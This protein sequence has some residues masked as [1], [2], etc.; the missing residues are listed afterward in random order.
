MR[1][2]LILAGLA[3]FAL[4]SAASAQSDVAACREI[5]DSLV[6]LRCYDDVTK[7]SAAKPAV[8]A[9]IGTTDP[10]PNFGRYPTEVYRGRI[11]TPDFRG[12]DRAYAMLRTRIRDGAKA[13]PNF[14][15]YL[16][17][18]EIGCGAGC[19]VVPVVD[20]RTG[21]VLDFPLGGEDNLSL[22]LKYRRDSRLIV[23]YWVNEGVCRRED[24]VWTGSGFER[25][26]TRELGD[27]EVCYRH[28]PQ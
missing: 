16:T 15:G 6:R 13:G 25:G 14:A 11:M 21:R 27:A 28:L 9:P 24:L 22:V 20:V 18:V 5:Q 2:A 12:R 19:R 7:P 23:A 8:P 3:F 4:S 10:E 26:T 17:L 1:A